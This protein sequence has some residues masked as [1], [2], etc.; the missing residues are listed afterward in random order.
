MAFTA[1][2]HALA[3]LVCLWGQLSLKLTPR[4]TPP[5]TLV[6]SPPRFFSQGQASLSGQSIL[7]FSRSIGL[8]GG[9]WRQ[10]S[11]TGRK[12]PPLS[13]HFRQLAVCLRLRPTSA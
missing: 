4:D 9:F 7:S 13:A 8:A 12:F 6:Y 11:A 3:I 10:R 1:V 5:S 2:L